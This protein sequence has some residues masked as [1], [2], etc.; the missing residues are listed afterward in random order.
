VEVTHCEV[1]R[2]PQGIQGKKLAAEIRSILK[3]EKDHL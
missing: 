1:K 3:K 2:D